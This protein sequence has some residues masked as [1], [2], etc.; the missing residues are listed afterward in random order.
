MK[1]FTAL[2][3]A[4]TYMTSVLAGPQWTWEAGKQT[5]NGAITVKSASG[6]GTYSATQNPTGAVAKT[7]QNAVTQAPTVIVQAT[8]SLPIHVAGDACTA[9]DSGGSATEG[10]AITEDRT[11]LLSCQSGSRSRT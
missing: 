3:L 6:G 5:T 4:L 10:V 8:A 11:L 9:A 7:N 2:V 1:Q